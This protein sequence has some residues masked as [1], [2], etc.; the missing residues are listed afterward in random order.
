[1]S[2]KKKI[3]VFDD[4]PDVGIFCKTVL[5]TRGWEVK[6]FHEAFG[7]E[8]VVEVEKPDL[9]ILDIMME[10]SD[11]GIRLARKLGPKGV[12]VFLLS[13]IARASGAVLDHRDLPVVEIINKP[14][15]PQ[16]L[17]HKVSQV[18]GEGGLV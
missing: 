15:E 17:V 2:K 14:I 4:D 12:P 16:E 3:L 11:S 7:A 18:L 6:V 5:E 9:V 10:Q 1:M 13:A 8:E